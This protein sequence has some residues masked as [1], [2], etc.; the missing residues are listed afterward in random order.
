MKDM[1]ATIH[2]VYLELERIE[3]LLRLIIMK[4]P[5]TSEKQAEQGLAEITVAMNALKEAQDNRK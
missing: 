2:D 3:V 4:M 1:Q 5:I